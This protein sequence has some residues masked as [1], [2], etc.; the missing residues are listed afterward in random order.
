ML[1]CSLNFRQFSNIIASRIL[2]GIFIG[3]YVPLEE[4]QYMKINQITH[5]VNCAAGE[6]KVPDNL[7]ELKYY[8]KDEDSQIIV[9]LETIREIQGFVGKALNRGESVLFCCV[10]GQSRSLTALVSYLMFRF[11][12]SLFKALQYINILKKEFEIR[13]SFLKQLIDFEKVEMNETVISRNWNK[14]PEDQDEALLQNTYLNSVQKSNDDKFMTTTISKSQNYSRKRV[15]WS[16]YEI[17][18]G[19]TEVC[20]NYSK[21]KK[22]VKSIL[23][24]SQLKTSDKN[25][26][27]SKVYTNLLNQKT[28]GKVEE[29]FIRKNSQKNRN[30]QSRTLTPLNKRKNIDLITPNQNMRKFLEIELQSKQFQQKFRSQTNTPRC[31]QSSRNQ[32]ASQ[33][34]ADFEL[35]SSKKPPRL[36]RRAQLKLF[37]LL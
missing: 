36:I 32:N 26:T 2:D 11:K 10:S 7:K 28:K 19:T 17:N 8:W 20:Y 14:T 5:V 1:N 9:T 33:I 6:I 34:S 35:E 29:L 12:W 37:Q 21:E 31:N 3:N 18:L 27:L 4:Q 24:S 23:K 25:N 16:R 15:S 13:A 22:I 30:I